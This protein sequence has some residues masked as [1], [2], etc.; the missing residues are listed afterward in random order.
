MLGV[1][2]PPP[3]HFPLGAKSLHK[4]QTPLKFASS[5]NSVPVTNPSPQ[6]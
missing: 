6:K 2:G 5:Q 3:V 4:M 1:E